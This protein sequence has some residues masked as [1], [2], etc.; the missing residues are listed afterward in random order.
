MMG[1]V[2]VDASVLVTTREPSGVHASV[3]VIPIASRAATVVTGGGAAVA[4]QPSTVTAGSVPVI[5]GA[6]LSSTLNIWLIVDA[7]PQASVMI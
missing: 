6:V 4:L 5:R 1:Q 2:E 3:M 7:L